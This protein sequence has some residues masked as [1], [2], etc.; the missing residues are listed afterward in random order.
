MKSSK[1][2]EL[3]GLCR[4]NAQLRSLYAWSRTTPL[5]KQGGEQRYRVQFTANQQLYEQLRQA[6]DL[7]RHQ[8][9]DGD[10][11]RL[12]HDFDAAS[13][14]LRLHRTFD[15]LENTGSIPVGRQKAV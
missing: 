3:A 11:A 4:F 13:L 2:R 8:V 14:V 7:L 9:P 15:A 10:L 12:I 1:V 6:Q 5:G